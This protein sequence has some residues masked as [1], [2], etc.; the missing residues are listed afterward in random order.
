[1]RNCGK[2][3]DEIDVNNR[4]NIERTNNGEDDDGNNGGAN[5]RSTDDGG[6]DGDDDED[7]EDEDEAEAEDEDEDEDEYEDDDEDED[8]DEESGRSQTL[9]QILDREHEVLL[10][11]A[12]PTAYYTED[13]FETLF[14]E[15]SKKHKQDA[16][17]HLVPASM[18]HSLSSMEYTVPPSAR[19]CDFLV[20]PVNHRSHWSV[21][22]ADLRGRHLPCP[23]EGPGA[24]PF[25][26]AVLDPFG[27]ELYVEAHRVVKFLKK[28]EFAQP[29][30]G[31]TELISRL[32][33][34]HDLPRTP[35]DE[36]GLFVLRGL[37]CFLHNPGAFFENA[38][39][40]PS[41]WAAEGIPTSESAHTSHDEVMQTLEA[42]ML[43]SAADQYV[44]DFKMSTQGYY[45]ALRRLVGKRFLCDD[46]HSEESESEANEPSDEANIGTERPAVVE[47]ASTEPPNLEPNGGLPGSASTEPV[48]PEPAETDEPPA[49][50]TLS[51]EPEERSTIHV[52]F[53]QAP[54]CRNVSL[55]R[56]KNMVLSRDPEPIATI[57]RPEPTT[58]LPP[59]TQ[60][61][62][63]Q[64]EVVDNRDDDDDLYVG[65]RPAE[66]KPTITG[67]HA[68]DRFETNFI[69]TRRETPG[70]RSA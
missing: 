61:A 14:A 48:E 23:A 2:F 22:F 21:I 8:E 52:A 4:G 68:Y 69:F 65:G 7:D 17:V 42:K 62:E 44:R 51:P 64:M 56:S 6:D 16:H 40:R 46:R 30:P 19:A 13:M 5:D 33:L 26:S 32:D 9:R 39:K 36:K 45:K 1:M 67:Q 35:H 11:Q 60:A 59:F 38:I 20:F 70:P 41:V 3:F 25:L 54:R 10:R 37:A 18:W 12:N 28:Y 66:S 15:L 53:Q 24:L 49:T 47:P 29:A 34:A 63:A 43:E 58:R 55:A 50:E 27:H 57:P 31:Q